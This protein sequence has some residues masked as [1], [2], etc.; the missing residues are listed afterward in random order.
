MLDAPANDRLYFADKAAP[1]PPLHEPKTDP[2]DTRT[3]TVDILY[4]ALQRLDY[5]GADGTKGTD[6]FSANTAIWELICRL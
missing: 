6:L 1:R 4:T 2:N 3:K 5:F